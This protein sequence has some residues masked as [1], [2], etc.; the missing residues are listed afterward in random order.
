MGSSCVLEKKAQLKAE[1]I[2]VL[3]CTNV[4]NAS[5]KSFRRISAWITKERWYMALY[6]LNLIS[7]ALMMLSQ[8][9]TVCVEVAVMSID[10]N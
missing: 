7:D 3:T 2:P 1:C 8:G 9:I 5:G 6:P 10:V 4:F